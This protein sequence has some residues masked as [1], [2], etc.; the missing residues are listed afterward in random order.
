MDNKSFEKTK[1]E[2][3]DLVVT[4]NDMYN[5]ETIQRSEKTVE[6]SDKEIQDE[7]QRAND[8]TVITDN[9]MYNVETLPP[10]D[11]HYSVPNLTDLSTDSG[12][13]EARD[14]Q[15]YHEIE[16]GSPVVTESN[17]EW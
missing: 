11:E 2:D 14:S 6:E 8:Y 5:I 3:D 7:K 4:Y 1:D 15:I 9:V 13:G 16:S 10:K 12:V 17:T